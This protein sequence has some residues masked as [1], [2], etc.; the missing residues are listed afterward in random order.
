MILSIALAS[1]TSVTGTVCDD[2][3]V[4][5]ADCTGSFAASS[6]ALT[7]HTLVASHVTRHTEPSSF[8]S[9]AP[10]SS[11]AFITSSSLAARSTRITPLRL[12]CHATA[13]G[14]AIEPPILL[15]IARTSDAVRLRLS[16]R[17]SISNATP[18]GAYAS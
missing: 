5:S 18:P 9:S 6:A 8:M 3:I 10:C 2:T 14:A 17:I 13:P 12:N 16:V 7:S 1:A 4:L 11:T 15:K